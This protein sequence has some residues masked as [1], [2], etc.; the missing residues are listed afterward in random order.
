MKRAGLTLSLSWVLLLTVCSAT[1]H[2]QSGPTGQ[3]SGQQPAAVAPAPRAPDQDAAK[4]KP[5]KVWTNDNVGDLRSPV[6]VVGN[7]SGA[8]N[9][10]MNRG[11]TN[12]PRDGRTGDSYRYQLQPLRAELE[13]IDRQIHTL[14]NFKADNTSPEG[15][16]RYGGNY[17]MVPVEQ[18]V[19]Q[20]EERKKSV[21][22]KIDALKDEARHHGVAPGDIR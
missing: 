21:Q 9:R 2:A 15:G 1:A 19:K 5:K 18:Q 17:N 3:S 14:K 13:N 7:H 22:A 11:M 20:L 12:F 4:K 6:S 8:A 10:G 16:V